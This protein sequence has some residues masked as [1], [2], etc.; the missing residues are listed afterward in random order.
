MNLK[1]LMLNKRNQ[2]KKKKKKKHRHYFA[3]KYLSNP[4]YGFSIQSWKDTLCE[5]WTI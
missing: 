5:N 1:N 3:K 2:K 4:G